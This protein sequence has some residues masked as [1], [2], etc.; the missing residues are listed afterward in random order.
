MMPMM[1]PQATDVPGIGDK[2]GWYGMG[3]IFGMLKGD[4]LLTIQFVGYLTEPV[5]RGRQAARG[6]GEPPALS[7]CDARCRPFFVP[8]TEPGAAGGT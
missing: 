7:P 2:T 8:C 4:T 1:M 3:K 5:P 6:E